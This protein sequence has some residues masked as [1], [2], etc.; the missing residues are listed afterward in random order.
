MNTLANALEAVRSETPICDA[1]ADEGRRWRVPDQDERIRL[2]RQGANLLVDG[3][4]ISVTWTDWECPWFE[5]PACGR[6]YKHLYLGVLLCR[7]C[8]R[9][10]YTCRRQ[11]DTGPLSDHYQL[12]RAHSMP[13]CVASESSTVGQ[14]LS[15]PIKLCLLLGVARTLPI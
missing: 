2:A 9:L 13:G 12:V 10:D 5:C 3:I 6:R 8:C 15:C 14:A 4:R 7:T 1:T 11:L